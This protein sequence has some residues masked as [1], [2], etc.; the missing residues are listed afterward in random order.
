[1]DSVLIKVENGDDYMLSYQACN[2]CGFFFITSWSNRGI[3]INSVVTEVRKVS[4]YDAD[5]LMPFIIEV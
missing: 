5:K 2:K 1:M 4:V 3:V